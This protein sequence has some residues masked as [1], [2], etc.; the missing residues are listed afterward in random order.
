MDNERVFAALE[1]AEIT[2]QAAAE[3]FQVTPQTLFNWKKG[4]APKNQQIKSRVEKIAG[5]IETALQR[6]LLPLDKKEFKRYERIEG[7]KRAITHV[8]T[9][10]Q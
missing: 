2:M 8:L 3:L 1:Q 6:G 10:G 9:S 5:A 4:G 7:V